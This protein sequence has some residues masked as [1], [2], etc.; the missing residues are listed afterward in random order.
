MPT[1]LSA[2][3]VNVSRPAEP[4]GQISTSGGA[5]PAAPFSAL[6]PQAGADGGAAAPTL[7]SRLGV[8]PAAVSAGAATAGEPA[9]QVA[10]AMPESSA[11][12]ADVP[13]GAAAGRS[14]TD[15]TV[16]PADARGGEKKARGS[17]APAA[18][19]PSANPP[20]TVVP[21]A[22]DRAGDVQ[23]PVPESGAPRPPAA[24]DRAASADEAMLPGGSAS[25]SP[26]GSA[27]GLGAAG[28]PPVPPG[29]QL[30]ITGTIVPVDPVFVQAPASVAGVAGRS[31][32]GGAGR[33]AEDGGPGVVADA[34]AAPPQDGDE[35]ADAG[36]RPGS[37]ADA[38]KAA[39]AAGAPATMARVDAAARTEERK[40]GDA[41]AA[42]PPD[43][44]AAVSAPPV[45]GTAQPA[46]SAAAPGAASAPPAVPI[47]GLAAEIAARALD[48][49]RRF[50]IRLDP[51]ELGRI[52]VRLDVGKDGRVTSRLVVERA[53][54][55]D[56]LRRDAPNLERALEAAG[57]RP[58]DS[59]LQFSLRDQ[60]Q[61]GAWPRFDDMPRPAMLILPDGD[62]AVHEAVRRGYGVLRGFGGGVDIRV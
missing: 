39:P 16:L 43:R 30:A 15:R 33:A 10:A 46:A 3:A 11:P 51:P 32:F 27:D 42:D 50:E 2:F 6:L 35:N 1:S 55:L 48:G 58:N 23:G 61:G 56:L 13:G 54:T 59:G 19:A 45:G 17:Q 41:I 38:A 53:E 44:N 36:A 7:K 52:D 31:P 18:P 34:D 40:S 22:I 60:S 9:A 12:V 4:S 8:A 14:P 21:A 57:L 29:G 24:D 49:K 62:I 28:M 37:T 26:S 25:G 5:P 20:A 47:I